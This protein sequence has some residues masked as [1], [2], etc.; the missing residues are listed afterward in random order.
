MITLLAPTC[1]H[2]LYACYDHIY[3]TNMILTTWATRP[4]QGSEWRGSGGGH[5]FCFCF[6]A[7]YYHLFYDSLPRYN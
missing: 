4:W 6:L 7:S 3:L 5:L 1:V 2:I